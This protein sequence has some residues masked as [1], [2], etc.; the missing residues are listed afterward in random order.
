MNKILT[1]GYEGLE[2][3]DFVE[4][5]I[6]AKVDMLVDV[7][8]IPTSRKRGFSKTALRQML[9]DAGIE[10]RHFRSLGSPKALRHAVR[11]DRDYNEFFSG[12]RNHLK[13]EESRDALRQIRTFANSY[14][15]CLLCFCKDW[16]KCHRREVVRELSA[17]AYIKIEHLAPDALHNSAA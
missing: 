5:L 6:S 8:E 7:R 10:Y 15:L 17:N 14:Q 9:N 4:R 11:K 2:I 16:R 13:R 12:V 3:G 1:V